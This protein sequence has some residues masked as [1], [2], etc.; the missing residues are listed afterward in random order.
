MPFSGKG[1]LQGIAAAGPGLIKERRDRKL[2]ERGLDIE[3]RGVG[4]QEKGLGL[5]ERELSQ[6]DAELLVLEIL[7]R[8]Q[9]T[10]AEANAA[11]KRG[12]LE[13]AQGLQKNVDQFF[14]LL[15]GGDTLT[16][17]PDTP[18]GGPAGEPVLAAPRTDIDRPIVPPAPRGPLPLGFPM[19]R[20]PETSTSPA[21]TTPFGQPRGGPFPM[22]GASYTPPGRLP[23][24]MEAHQVSGGEAGPQAGKHPTPG[25]PVTFEERIPSAP[26]RLGVNP[27]TPRMAPQLP[28]R[29]TVEYGQRQAP[30]ARAATDPGQRQPLLSRPLTRTGFPSTPRDRPPVTGQATRT[31]NLARLG[32]APAGTGGPSGMMRGLTPRFTNQDALIAQAMLK[33]MPGVFGRPSQFAHLDVVPRETR[34][35]DQEAS[36]AAVAAGRHRAEREDVAPRAV[37]DIKAGVQPLVR[38]E[39]FDPE[40]GRNQVI[41]DQRSVVA[42]IRREMHPDGKYRPPVSDTTQQKINEARTSLREIER[43]LGWLYDAADITMEG[44]EPTFPSVSPTD[45]MTTVDRGQFVDFGPSPNFGPI[46]GRFALFRMSLP[47]ELG[48]DDASLATLDS[49]MSSM[50]SKVIQLLS[51]AA[52]SEQEMLRMKRQLPDIAEDRLGTLF[53][54]LYVMRLRARD[55]VN[56]TQSLMELEDYY[57]SGKGSP[58]SDEQLEALLRQL[59]TNYAGEGARTTKD[60][61]GIIPQP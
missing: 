24:R 19:H 51:G 17:R 36:A 55:A 60:G 3:E 41:E 44:G 16:R 56:A 12:E 18:R 29:P 50:K 7:R 10:E 27:R 45:R 59:D 1:F 5:R 23:D 15:G 26:G 6:R 46:A 52:V 13:Y 9:A 25:T 31:F 34:L 53:A 48:I 20:P 2:A 11:W 43:T 8:A 57:D 47:G 32:G 22:G 14:A 40:T 49:G 33:G 28:S 58:I 35:S 4:V 39:Y 30:P 37:A 61:I 38:I 42:E 54:K 21:T